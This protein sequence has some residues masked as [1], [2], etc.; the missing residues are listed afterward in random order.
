MERSEILARRA[1]IREERAA[2]FAAIDAVKDAAKKMVSDVEAKFEPVRIRTA[3]E[4]KTLQRECPHIFAE[5]DSS[6]ASFANADHMDC[7]DCGLSKD[8][9]TQ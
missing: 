5:Y 2:A 6:K 3:D 4:L 9:I 8:L 7:P 1:A